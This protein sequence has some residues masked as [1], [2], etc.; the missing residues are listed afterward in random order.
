MCNK[1]GAPAAFRGYRLQSLYIMYRI[2]EGNKNLVYCPEKSEDLTIVNVDTNEEV[3]DIQIKAHA[4]NNLSL[5]DF[6]I[7]KPEGFFRR[8]LKYK[9]S[10]NK[11]KVLIVSF[12]KVGPELS[13]A[14]K[15][16]D[17]KHIKSIAKKLKEANFEKDDINFFFEI[18]KI[19]ECSEEDLKNKIQ[20]KLIKSIFSC[21]VDTIFDNLNAWIYDCSEFKKSINQELLDKKILDIGKNSNAQLYYN[22]NWF[23]IIQ[24]LEDE[25]ELVNEKDFYQGSITKF[26][27]INNNL[28]IKRCN[29]L[30][31]INEKHNKHNIV[32]MHGASGQGKSTLAYRYMKDYFPSYRRFEIIEKGIENTEKVL[33]IAQCIKGVAN[34]IKDYDIPIGFYIDIPPREIKWI[35]LLKEIVGVKG[36]Y[37]LITIREEDWNRSE[38]ETD[39]LTWEDLELTFS[40][41]ESEDFYNRYMKE[42]RNDKFL[43]FEESWTS[44][45]GKGPLLEYA[46]FINSGI[47][48]RKKIKLQIEKIEKEKNEISLDILEMVSLAST[49]DSRISLKKLALFLGRYNKECLKYLENEYLIITNKQDKTVEGLHFVRSQIIVASESNM[50]SLRTLGRKNFHPGFLVSKAHLLLLK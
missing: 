40:K 8:I 33:E 10:E 24:R 19:L 20:E 22:E 26:C 15:N 42:L 29:W 25:T 47:T 5:K 30:E 48:L 45:G 12:D 35:E 16:K 18:I 28:D 2:L 1:S 27:H 39:N 23:K 43:N 36:I 41:E 49:Y 34:N 31:K 9:Y 6:N 21:S 38:G 32:I 3:E 50:S 13:G 11:P 7:N 4:S 44:F 17:D 37:I 46:Y 14:F